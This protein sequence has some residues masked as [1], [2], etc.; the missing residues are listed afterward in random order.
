MSNRILSRGVTRKKPHPSK[1]IPVIS[2][3]AAYHIREARNLQI[4]RLEEEFFL[5]NRKNDRLKTVYE[6]RRK[7]LLKKT[8]FHVAAA[9]KLLKENN[10]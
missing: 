5:A 10:K 2:E 8:R 3:E 1:N 6:N 4:N 9:R 7:R